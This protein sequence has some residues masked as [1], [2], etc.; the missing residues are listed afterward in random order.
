MGRGYRCSEGGEVGEHCGRDPSCF[1]EDV[2]VLSLKEGI[3]PPE[4]GVGPHE[5]DVFQQEV[6][7]A[8]LGRAF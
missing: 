6:S 7:V 2:L 5:R 4:W 8:G 3:I 1:D